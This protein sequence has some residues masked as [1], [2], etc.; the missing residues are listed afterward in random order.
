MTR[1]RSGILIFSSLHHGSPDLPRNRAAGGRKA[2]QQIPGA[3]PPEALHLGLVYADHEHGRHRPPRLFPAAHFPRAPDHRQNHLR[4]QPRAL[5]ARL[6]RHHDALRPLPA[7]PAQL[8]AAP[9]RVALLPH[10]APVHRDHHGG[11]AEIRRASLGVVA[12]RRHPRALLDLRRRELP[13]RRRAVLPA[14]HGPQAPD[15]PEHDALV[16]PTHISHHALRHHRQRLRRLAIPAARA[17]HPRRG[18]H[19][20]GPR[21]DGRHA[22]VRPVHRALDA[23]RPPGAGPPPGDVHRSRSAGVHG[24]GA[25]RHGRRPARRLRLRGHAPRGGGRA[26]RGRTLRGHL[27]VEPEPVVLR[28]RARQ[29][30]GLCPAYALSSV[31][32]VVCVPER[33]V[34]ARDD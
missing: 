31:V 17:A 19:L 2:H 5:R 33:G 16:D 18:A 27:L 15:H 9:H 13:R 6:H 32:V 10:S 25:D 30:R 23:V 1:G 28:H 14:L 22:H 29:L 34:H 7:D 24:A 12:T 21:H 4:A 20:P 26:G 3:Q 8:P 11:H